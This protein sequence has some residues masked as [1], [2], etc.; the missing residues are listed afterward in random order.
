MKFSELLKESAYINGQWVDAK[1][2]GKMEVINPADG[3]YI[4]SVPDLDVDDAKNAIAA[5]EV[6]F[7]SWK[8]TTA[9][10]RA[11]I[12]R[13]WFDLITENADVLAELLTKEQ[14]KPLREAKGEVLS[15]ASFFE[16][17]GEEAKRTYGENIPS[18]MG[19]TRL[20]TIKQPIG[21]VTAITPWNFPISMIAR[22]AAPAIAAGC[23]IVIKPAEDTPLCALALAALA[24]EAG[25]PAGVINVVTTKRPIEVG[26][27]LCT[28]PIVKKV[29]FTGS[30]PVGKIILGMAAETVKK[31]SMELGG[32]APFIVF[33]DAD[34]E[35]A[36]AGA[37]ASK[38]RNAGQ[39]CICT[40]R[41]YIQA[42][43]YD[44]F[45]TRFKEEVEKLALGSGFDSS[46]DIGP[47]I[48]NAAVDKIDGLVQRAV[49]EGAELKVGGQRDAAGE[50]FYQPT[51]LANVTDEME[52][53][54]AELFGPI[55]TLFSFED[56]AEVIERANNTPFGLAAYV[57]TRDIGRVWR[58][59]EDLEYGMV[60][61]NEGLISNELAPF[62]GVKE[63]GV[64]REGSKHG[65]D[66]YMELKYICMG[67]I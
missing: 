15:C 45:A 22:K 2:G 1:C 60:G 53:S 17:F 18:N 57:Y 7:H 6:A 19:S 30:T 26:R 52:I 64:G 49:Q 54:Q 25:V 51:L 21:V 43:I 66:D 55:S 29:S 63:S 39:T 24:E 5:A 40:N 32:N 27:E 14:G 31:A 13:R 3:S 12:L 44:A 61:V 46:T 9:K 11:A 36:V 56:E 4:A 23:T 20:L 42:G 47:L 59:S 48:N 35:S 38:Y 16:W 65:M 41:F 8:K 67:G 37:I 33:D 58:V 62:G 28:N 50:R 10:A 34:L